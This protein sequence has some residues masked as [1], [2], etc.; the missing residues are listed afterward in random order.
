[1]AKFTSQF[2]T[3]LHKKFRSPFVIAVLE[4]QKRIAIASLKT[5]SGSSETK[6]KMDMDWVYPFVN[7]L[8]ALIMVTFG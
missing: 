7:E 4:S 5:T 1:V 8:F 3:A 6:L 2:S